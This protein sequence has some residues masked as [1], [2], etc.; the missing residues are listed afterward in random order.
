MRLLVT[1]AS[2][3]IGRNL[4]LAI[5]RRWETIALFYRSKDFVHFL[6]KNHLRQIRP[7][8]CDLSDLHDLKRKVLLTK[9]KYD[10]CIFLAANGN[11]SLSVTNPEIDFRMTTLTFLNFLS[12]VKVK[13]LLYVSSGAVYDGHHGLVSP[14]TPL[15]PRLPYAIH[16]R[17]AERTLQFFCEKMKNPKEYLIIRFFGAYGPYEPPRKIFTR[18]VHSFANGKCRSFTI[19]GNGKNLID[20][21][22][23][24]DAVEGLLR[25]LQSPLKN[26]T[27]DLCSGRPLS[28]E[29]LVRKGALLFGCKY[30]K[31]RKG[32]VPAEPIHFRASSFFQKKYLHF[33]PKISLKEGLGRL[34]I[35]LQKGSN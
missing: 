20:A 35:F 14:R 27:F 26:L 9:K 16:K 18:L 28:I 33:F 24:T 13:R 32:G 3:F 12:Q 10:A 23:V 30:V 4:L 31:I 8:R 11:P 22:Y 25:A 17:M 2:G 15:R 7:L 5:P 34:A 29:E 1:G 19:R 21:M 6:R